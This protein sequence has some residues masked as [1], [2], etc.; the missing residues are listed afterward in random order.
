MND[1]SR[2]YP[3]LQFFNND[4]VP[5]QRET[6]GICQEFNALAFKMAKTPYNRETEMALRKLLEAR[7]CFIRSAQL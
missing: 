6:M 7:D 1:R 3:I 4:N 2:R 5:L